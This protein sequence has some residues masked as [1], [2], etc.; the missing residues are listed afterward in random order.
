MY[1]NNL[2]IQDIGYIVVQHLLAHGPEKYVVAGPLKNPCA[3]EG[4]L[5]TFLPKSDI[6][7]TLA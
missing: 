6:I 7:R 2:R 3:S 4:F 5:L 1:G